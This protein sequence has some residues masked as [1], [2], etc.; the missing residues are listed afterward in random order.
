MK[1]KTAH[2]DLDQAWKHQD[3]A[4]ALTGSLNHLQGSTLSTTNDKD[5]PVS[6]LRNSGASNFKKVRSDLNL[7]VRNE[8]PD[9][10]GRRMARPRFDQSKINN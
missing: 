9:A 5:R 3:G 10:G 7:D 4:G 8:S 6:R 2:G 1:S